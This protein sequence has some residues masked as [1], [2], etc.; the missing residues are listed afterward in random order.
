MADIVDINYRRAVMTPIS[1]RHAS[2]HRP[3]SLSRR[4]RGSNGASPI[5]FSWYI[6]LSGVPRYAKCGGVDMSAILNAR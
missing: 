6:L 1:L 2:F 5:S 3:A 4:Q